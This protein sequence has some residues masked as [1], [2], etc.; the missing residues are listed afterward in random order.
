METRFPKTMP[1]VATG[2]GRHSSRVPSL[3]L[4]P[5][6]A[7]S[8]PDP[9]PFL[10]SAT[11]RPTAWPWART[12]WWWTMRKAPCSQMWTPSLSTRSGTP[13]WCGECPPL[14]GPWGKRRCGGGG[15]PRYARTCPHPVPGP[16]PHPDRPADDPFMQNGEMLNGDGRLFRL[17]QWPRVPRSSTWNK[18]PRGPRGVLPEVS[19][20]EAKPGLAVT[21]CLLRAHLAIILFNCHNSPRQG[22]ETQRG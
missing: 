7:G 10:C 3:P 20:P 19:Q 17:H 18:D 12:T 14:H 6:R 5:A 15:G 8:H 11:P 1:T 21:E 4:W 2:L 9:V 16:R 13:S 22:T